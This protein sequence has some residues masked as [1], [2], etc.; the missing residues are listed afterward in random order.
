MLMYLT[1]VGMSQ[2][3]KEHNIRPDLTL[4]QLLG[5]AQLWLSQGHWAFEFAQPIAPNY[6]TIGGITVKPV[7]PL[8]KV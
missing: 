7:K 2:I 1:R 3:Q 5:K 6:V 8:P 4:G